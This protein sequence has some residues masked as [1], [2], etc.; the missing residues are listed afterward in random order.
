MICGRPQTESSVRH[1]AWLSR[2]SL[3][4]Y[5]RRCRTQLH[6]SRCFRLQ[7][8]PGL[9]QPSNLLAYYQGAEDSRRLMQATSRVTQAK[10]CGVYL[11]ITQ[12]VLKYVHI[13][14][15]IEFSTEC[16]PVLFLLI[17]SILS[18][19]QDRSM[20][21]HVFF[22]VFPSRLSFPLSFVQS[23]ILES[24]SCARYDQSSQPSFFILYVGISSPWPFVTF[25]LCS[26]NRSKWS[27]QSF[28]ST[29]FKNFPATSY[30][31]SELSKFQYHRYTILKLRKTYRSLFSFH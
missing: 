30:L 25:L 27:S 8:I 24:S 31:L 2:G 22:L 19:P 16:E 21:G 1:L 14:F 23:R 20:S 26:Q 10:R 6:L 28:F 3:T 4:S 15:R 5:D 11:V 29:S 13:L 18:Y 9:L 17:S 7:N 12:S